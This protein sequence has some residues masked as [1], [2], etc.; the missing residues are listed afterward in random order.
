M[1]ILSCCGHRLFDIFE[2]LAAMPHGSGNTGQIS[3]WCA[4]FAERRGLRHIR[5]SRDNVVIFKDASPGCEACAPVILQAHLDMVCVHE[6][7]YDIDMEKQPVRLMTDGKT[8]WADRTSLG[9]DNLI[10]VSIILAILE[11]DSPA[12]PPI[13]AVLTS[14]EET[15][16]HGALALDC[17]VLK[18]RKLINLD[19]GSDGNFTVCCAGGLL[20][21][22]RIPVKYD[23]LESDYI[24]EKIDINGLSGGHSASKIGSGRANANMVMAELLSGLGGGIPVRLCSFTG[25]AAENAIAFSS[26]AVLAIPA[27]SKESFN[28]HMAVA[29]ALLKR[30]YAATDPSLYVTWSEASG[31]DRAL[32]AMRTAEVTALMASLPYGVIAFD[33]RFEGLPRTSLNMGIVRIEEGVLEYHHYL[34]ST[35]NNEIS[36]LESVL[37]TSAE[38]LGG[39]IESSCGYPAWDFREDSPLRDLLM[40]SYE[41][42][43]GRKASFHGTHGGL[44]CGVLLSKLPGADIVA[45]NPDL[46]DV[47]SVRERL[48]VQSSKVLYS[49][50]SRALEKCAKGGY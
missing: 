5:D 19:S 4:S 6:P 7:D 1:G 29:A 39:S 45:A 11:D 48:D 10:G 43:T 13:E 9:A 21:T 27:D 37:K 28:S 32:S 14:D 25:G 22:S 35:R 3:A 2:E 38:S 40:E 26:S 24:L 46:R 17:S 41:E 30:R 8:V 36:E 31:F 33:T 50:V 44:E 42:V 23:A 15:G 16:M 18:G 20:V 49:V 47:H 12:H 34:R